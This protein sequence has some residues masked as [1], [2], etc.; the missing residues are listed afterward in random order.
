MQIS[1][2]F[3]NLKNRKSWAL[4]ILKSLAPRDLLLGLC[5]PQGPIC[6]SI[7]NGLRPHTAN[8]DLF[9]SSIELSRCIIITSGENCLN[10]PNSFFTYVILLWA[11]KS[12]RIYLPFSPCH[13]SVPMR[14]F[15]CIRRQR[16]RCMK[17]VEVPRHYM[18][19]TWVLIIILTKTRSSEDSGKF[20]LN[21]EEYS[22]EYTVSFVTNIIG[23]VLMFCTVFLLLIFKEYLKV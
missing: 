13:F 16:S 23:Y 22:K 7:K 18:N 20:S 14:V 10:L 9:T 8:T 15:L 2:N 1:N 5:V 4:K 12:Y 3:E 17:S 21:F 19:C 6:L 11:P